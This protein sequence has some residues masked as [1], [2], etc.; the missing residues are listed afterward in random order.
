MYMHMYIT[1]NY[2]Y[3]CVILLPTFLSYFLQKQFHLYI[4]LFT[5]AYEHVFKHHALK[6]DWNSLKCSI[7][8]IPISH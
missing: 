3:V 5:W 6:T 1:V 2:I 7:L 4:S 8:W